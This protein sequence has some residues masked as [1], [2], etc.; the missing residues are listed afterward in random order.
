MLMQCMGI[1]YCKFHTPTINVF[2]ILTN[3]WHLL[4]TQHFNSGL[5]LEIAVPALILSFR[6][7]SFDATAKCFINGLDEGMEHPEQGHRLGKWG[8][9]GCA[10][11]WMSC[12]SEGARGQEESRGGQ[13]RERQSC[14]PEAGQA[15]GQ[16]AGRQLCRAGVPAGPNAEQEPAVCPHSSGLPP[17]QQHCW[18]ILER[19][20]Q[21]HAELRKGLEHLPHRQEVQ[22]TGTASPKSRRLRGILSMNSWWEKV[23]KMEPDSSQW[24]LVKGKKVRRAKVENS[25]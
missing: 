24:C 13:Q 6:G 8:G 4:I 19:A 14:A 22:K 1:Q 2:R 20:L 23:R 7:I 9:C 16:L 10:T 21:R 17:F 12:L 11:R 25:I 5:N 15:G 3:F 18:D